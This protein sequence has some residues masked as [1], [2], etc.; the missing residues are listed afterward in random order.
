MTWLYL[1]YLFKKRLPSKCRLILTLVA[2]LCVQ[3]LDFMIQ[4]I[5]SGVLGMSGTLVAE[6]SYESA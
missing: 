2:G 1:N 3:I 5:T 4:T 6:E